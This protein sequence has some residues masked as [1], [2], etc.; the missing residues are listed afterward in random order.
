MEAVAAVLILLVAVCLLLLLLSLLS[1]DVSDVCSGVGGSAD[2]NMVCGMVFTLD[3]VEV[4]L[5]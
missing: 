5:R 2:L 1:D 4:N 3:S